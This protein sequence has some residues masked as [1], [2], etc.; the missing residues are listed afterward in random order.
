MSDRPG[1]SLTRQEFDAVIRRAAELASTDTE[2][3]EGALTEGELFRIA[4]EVGLSDRHVRTAL[5]E[6]R[7]GVVE[8]GTLDRVFG[9]SF[10]RA[11]R[12]VPGT[13]DELAER[14]DDFFVRTQLLHSVRR[15]KDVLQYRPSL[16]W[17][18]QLAR[19]ASFT[20]RKYYVAS[21]KS[22][23][24]HLEEMEPG[25]TLVDMVVDPG[26]RG[27]SVA[28]GLIGGG[29]VGTGLG[30]AAAASL[31]TAGVALAVASG[32]G[33]VVG[34][35]LLGGISYAVGLS[36]KK[37]LLDVQAEVEGILD[38]LE[39]GESLEPPPASWRSWVK[40]QFHGVARELRSLDRDQ[41]DDGAED[42]H[43]GS[44]RP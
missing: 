1:K 31:S 4:R 8:S 13:P 43:G 9:P 41:D 25:F 17:A 18:S 38:R 15:S 19:A 20:S 7:T 10:V 22:V 32:V 42:G 14:L 12:V 28:G 33:I 2:G 39:M 16:D 29:T 24:I 3:S 44:D 27:D 37:K 21:A 30:I 5:S 26:T 35:G 34:G 40:R 11:V 6:V 36:H 23:E